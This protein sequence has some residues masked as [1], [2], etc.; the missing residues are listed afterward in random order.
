M[1]GRAGRA[2]PV[3]LLTSGCPQRELVSL[4]RRVSVSGAGPA[5]AAGR[6][7]GDLAARLRRAT[8][9]LEDVQ[10]ASGGLALHTHDPDEVRTQLR[11]CLVRPQIKCFSFSIQWKIRMD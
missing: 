5:A 9:T 4:E 3:L 10:R 6:L 1:E 2:G 8:E 7:P 11:A